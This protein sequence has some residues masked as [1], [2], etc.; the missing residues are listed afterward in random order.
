MTLSEYRTLFITVTLVLILIAASPVLGFVFPFQGSER[1]SE[2]WILGPEH[3][4]KDYPFNIRANETYKIFVGV[5]NHMASSSYYAVY[6]KFRNQ[7]EPLP[8]ITA[9]APSPLPVLYEYCI[10][11]RDGETWEGPLAFSISKVSFS[12]NHSS[13]RALTVNNVTFSVDKQVSWD[14]RQKGFYYQLFIELWIY[15]SQSDAFQ[16]HNRFVSR[17]LN[18]TSNL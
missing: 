3:M 6:V 8:N 17:W 5:G 4:A 11:I 10:L 14:F 13:I 7:T 1:F 12:E 9:G 16:F 15:N 18:V 2:L